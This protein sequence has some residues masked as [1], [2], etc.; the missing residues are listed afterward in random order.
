MGS[1]RLPPSALPGGRPRARRARDDRLRRGA[2]A[3][4]NMTNTSRGWRW[5]NRTMLA[6]STCSVQSTIACST[7]ISTCSLSR[8]YRTHE[9]FEQPAENAATPSESEPRGSQPTR[10]VLPDVV[11]LAYADYH[12]GPGHNP[13]GD[14]GGARLTPQYGS[15]LRYRRRRGEAAQSTRQPRQTVPWRQRDPAPAR[16]ASFEQ[17]NDR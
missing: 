7:T 11:L 4:M 14:P 2:E 15:N 12:Q 6:L 13:S 5:R 8:R 17:A 1:R 3:V 16:R 9:G 10:P